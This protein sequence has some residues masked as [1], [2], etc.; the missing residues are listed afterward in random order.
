MS[1]SRISSF[2]TKKRTGPTEITVHIPH[3]PHSMRQEEMRVLWL[4]LGDQKTAI[5][6]SKTLSTAQGVSLS[7]AVL[8]HK[9][10]CGSQEVG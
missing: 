4:S 8:A 1:S 10:A 3:P 6:P 5:K 9:A 2:V 7:P